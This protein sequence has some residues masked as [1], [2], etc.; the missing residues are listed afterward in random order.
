M[1]DATLQHERLLA[2]WSSSDGNF[3]LT[4][5]D[6]SP[7]IVVNL[8]GRYVT[9]TGDNFLCNWWIDCCFY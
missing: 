8:D 1:L 4:P 7:S 6:G 2:S 9:D 3:T 5:N